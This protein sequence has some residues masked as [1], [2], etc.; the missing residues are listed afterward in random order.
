MRQH[1]GPGRSYIDRAERAVSAAGHRIV[2]MADFSAEDTKPAHVCEREVSRADVYVGII[3][4]RYGSLVRDHQPE[5]SY[6][7]LE[8]NTATKLGKP[9]LLFLL[10][11]SSTDTELGIPANALNDLEHGQRQAA[12]RR[13]LRESG[14]TVDF[15]R[16][17]DDLYGK[18][19]HALHRLAERLG[20]AAKAESKTGKAEQVFPGPRPKPIP[21]LLPYLPDRHEQDGVLGAA[22]Q[23]LMATNQPRPMVV[24]LHGERQ[25]AVSVY[26]ERF[27][28]HNAPRLLRGQSQTKPKAVTYPL[29]EP[30]RLAALTAEG[31]LADLNT[32]LLMD[33]AVNMDL[34][35]LFA[36]RP[37][38]IILSSS[39]D[40]T[41]WTDGGGGLLERVCHFWRNC[42]AVQGKRL[43]HFIVLSYRAP[44]PPLIH[45]PALRWLFMRYWHYKWR[46][47][48]HRRL[49]KQLDATLAR[50]SLS[51]PDSVV[52]PRFES[53]N[54]DDTHQWA[55][56][57]PVRKFLRGCDRWRFKRELDR[58]YSEN[59]DPSDLRPLPMESLAQK[60]L[61]RLEA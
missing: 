52:L 4:L 32:R 6:T 47:N 42:Q 51:A 61:M 30:S 19:Y 7:E 1:P 16:N 15:F 14:A 25:Q 44:D 53:V 33:A 41:A 59:S 37:E 26:V 27:L 48:S 18:L 40:P 11:D 13:R 54:L 56:S 35:D 23:R 57:Y 12:F 24:I 46:K 45:R 39:I 21:G 50:I 22:F 49:L 3:G 29:P 34:S 31:F 9:L 28:E 60:L 43:I 20:H 38:P 17:P 10:N 55:D 8:F 2:D 5:V 58:L 36:L